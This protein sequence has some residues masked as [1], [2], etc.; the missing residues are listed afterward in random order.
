MLRIG[1]ERLLYIREVQRALGVGF[2][3]LYKCMEKLGIEP[4][5]I[6]KSKVITYEEFLKLKENCKAHGKRGRP[7]KEESS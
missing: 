4:K 7:P 6:G 5:P 1:N 2:A 3:T